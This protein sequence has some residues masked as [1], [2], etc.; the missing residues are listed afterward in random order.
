MP[1]GESGRDPRQKGDCGKD[2]ASTADDSE[3][4]PD[5]ERQI[6]NP[7]SNPSKATHH[8]T[9]HQQPHRFPKL[10]AW[11][12]VIELSGLLVLII[13]TTVAAC[14]WKATTESNMIALSA[15]QAGDRPYVLV[16]S[17]DPDVASTIS[18]G[19]KNVGRGLALDLVVNTTTH[20]ATPA[21]PDE[22]SLDAPTDPS[23]VDVSSGVLGPGSVIGGTISGKGITDD[24]I[25]KIKAGELRLY[26]YG[27][28][29]YR[30]IYGNRYSPRFCRFYSPVLGYFGDCPKNRFTDSGGHGYE[31]QHAP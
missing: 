21:G 4:E 25:S 24:E 18:M 5:I 9:N 31:P 3:G 14:Q 30:D 17:L 2:D 29:N 10:T 22:Y 26:I 15:L 8:N 7:E 1:D 11:Q 27:E 13:Y 28:F 6:T 12:S 19:V 16:D 23:G 20:I